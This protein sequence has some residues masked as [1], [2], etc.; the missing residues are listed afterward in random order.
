MLVGRG[1]D[2]EDDDDDDDDFVDASQNLE[3][4]SPGGKEG[5]KCECLLTYWGGDVS[6]CSLILLS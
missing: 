1:G 3:K 2:E 5:A 6:I 4:S